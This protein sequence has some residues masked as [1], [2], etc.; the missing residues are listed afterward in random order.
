[1]VK[2]PP[3]DLSQRQQVPAA[4]I[5]SFSPLYVT[6]GIIPTATGIIFTPYCACTVRWMIIQ[7]L[8]NCTAQLLING[9][10]ASAVYTLASGQFV[11]FAGR[12]LPN[13]AQVSVALTPATA[14]V[15]EVVWTKEI[16]NAIT[17]DQTS[18]FS[19]APAAASP[20]T[21]IQ[22]L[23][24]ALHVDIDNFTPTK[25][26]Y[27]IGDSFTPSATAKAAITIFGSATK[28][29]KITRILCSLVNTST[30]AGATA[31]LFIE[32]NTAVFT[33]GTVTVETPVPNDSA[34]PAA[35]ATVNTYSVAPTGGGGT[36]TAVVGCRG[37]VPM[38]N[39]ATLDAGIGGLLQL[40]YTPGKNAKPLTLNG[41]AQGLSIVPFF[42]AG[43]ISGAYSIEWTEE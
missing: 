7:V 2:R 25:A 5:P 20:T 14:A 6:S 21:V 22:P 8:G 19:G 36:P 42:S 43:V 27:S 15:Y 34:D 30:T 29:V 40:E 10:P 16:G 35:T 41:V 3:L 11:R 23:G 24:S 37:T 39:G 32:K 12:F 18:V 13:N 1:M 9:E 26:T 28:T 4:S 38:I 17:V 33:G 31:V